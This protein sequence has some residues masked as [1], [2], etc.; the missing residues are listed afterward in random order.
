MKN[1]CLGFI[2]MV[3][4]SLSVTV[5]SC[6]K[7]EI[8]AADKEEITDT[9]AVVPSLGGYLATTGKLKIKFN[10]TSY[11]FDARADSI[12][13]IKVDTAGK[14]YFGITA[15][16]DA[17]TISFGI[18]GKGAAADKIE[19]NVAGTQ[20]LFRQ[21]SIQQQAFTLSNKA[22]ALD[23]GNFVLKKYRYANDELVLKGT[24][25]AYLASDTDTTA[26]LHKVTGS[27]DLKLQ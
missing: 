11:V 20:F 13:F 9:A 12:A 23:I 21:N 19:A 22:H 27:F 4:L 24:F 1:K 14:Q 16:N 3:L 6:R 18:S 2:A 5:T 17:H 7:D 26:Q 15:I 10:D 25:T 8:Q